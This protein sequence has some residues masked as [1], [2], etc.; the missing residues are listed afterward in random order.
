MN[1]DLNDIAFYDIEVFC[2]DFMVVFL[3]PPHDET[4]RV[5]FHNSMTSTCGKFDLGATCRGYT[6]CGFN[7]YHYDD[8]VIAHV[9]K[10]GINNK[11]IKELN[12]DIIE[13]RNND[14]FI[15]PFTSLDCRQQLNMNVSLK[16]YEGAIFEPILESN[17]SFLI[18]RKLND[19]EV[20]ETIEY[21][22]YDVLLTRKMFFDRLESYFRPKYGMIHNVKEL[23]YNTTTLAT[24]GFEKNPKWYTTRVPSKYFELIPPEIQNY[25]NDEGQT[26]EIDAY[27]CKIK[28][29]NGG[30]HGVNKYKSQ[31]AKGTLLDVASMYP[32]IIKANN[33]LGSNSKKF[34]RMIE[35]RFEAK[36][37]GLDE[38][39]HVLKIKINSIYGLLNNQYSNIYNP[40]GALTVCQ[41]G[42][43]ACYHLCGMLFNRGYN[44]ININT[45]GVLVEGVVPIEV[46]ESINKEFIE[47]FDLSLDYDA[48]E[49]FTQKDVNNYCCL[50]N[51][52]PKTKGIGYNKHAGNFIL[53]NVNAPTRFA[54][55]EE[56][57]IQKLLYG[58]EFHDTLL[59]NQNNYKM[60]Q[61]I[62]KTTHA[63]PLIMDEHGNEYKTKVNRLFA[64]KDG[65]SLYKSKTGAEK[66]KIEGVPSSVVVCNDLKNLDELDID[67]MF[68]INEAERLLNSWV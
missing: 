48:I 65:V 16:F 12:D 45:D 5:V 15:T 23:K 38:L 25:F 27:N 20:E 17:V 32:N 62:T 6:L 10:N 68:Y 66:H 21:C 36:S 61:Y 1:L 22:Y 14:R 13:G 60:F 11:H 18:D 2:E 63:Y 67:Y 19:E 34:V 31:I 39:Q 58:K 30:L 33:I 46:Y 43:I 59:D 24:F 8:K 52:K 29:G 56:L 41:I 50:V 57:V 7:N 47:M 55:I 37:Q 40:M 42:Q 3:L 28:F 51:G 54:I 9:L 4:H 53:N 35:D 49:N 26:C 44:I 64:V